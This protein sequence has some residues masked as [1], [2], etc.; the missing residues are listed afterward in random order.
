MLEAEKKKC[1]NVPLRKIKKMKKVTKVRFNI[2][3][4]SDFWMTEEDEEETPGEYYQGDELESQMDILKELE[5]SI[6][7]G[8]KDGKWYPTKA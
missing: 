3:M 4:Y 1:L 2:I 5:N 8:K 6:G 7:A